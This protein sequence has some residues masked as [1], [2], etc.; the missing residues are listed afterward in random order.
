MAERSAPPSWEC[1]RRTVGE[2]A[3]ADLKTARKLA[4][5]PQLR[6]Q[7][8]P[9]RFRDFEKFLASAGVDPN[10][11]VEELAWGSWTRRRRG[12]ARGGAGA[13]R[14][15]NSSEARF[16]QQKLPT[17]EVRGYHLYAFSGG[18]SSEDICSRSSTR[19]RPPS[20]P[21]RALEKLIDVRDGRIRKH[22]HQRQALPAD[23]R[24]ERHGLIWAVLDQNYSHVAMQQLVPQASQ[25]PQARPSW[26]ASRR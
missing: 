23:Q 19:I 17:V 18:K 6:E 20:A 13:I 14:S 11:Q 25:F 26:T 3:Y 22:A 12:C 10:T 7:L 16:K 9:S 15:A 4:W 8:L 2:I 1:S 24:I 5:F 21:A